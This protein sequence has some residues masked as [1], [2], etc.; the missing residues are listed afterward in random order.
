MSWQS[1][2]RASGVCVDGGFCACSVGGSVRAFAAGVLPS[3]RCMS[4][5][6]SAAASALLPECWTQLWHGELS[7]QRCRPEQVL[8]VL[9]EEE[10]QHDQVDDD[11]E[12]IL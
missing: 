10:L 2:E 4:T 1:L 8:S 11:I 3:V 9:P 7:E 12:E 5:N 6:G